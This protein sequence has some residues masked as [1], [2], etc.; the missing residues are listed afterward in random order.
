MHETEDDLAGLETL[1]DRSYAAAGAHLRSIHTRDRRM[2]ARQVADRLQG[3]CL[4]VVATVTADGRPLT[5]PVDGVF[6]RGSFHVGTDAGS[7]RWRHVQRNPAVSATH[8]PGEA[9]AVT[10]HGRAVPAD[11]SAADTSGL[12]SA[13]LEIYLPRY[14]P[15]WQDFLD[16]GPVYL[17]IEAER[18]FAVDVTAGSSTYSPA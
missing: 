13:L 9:W 15:G 2:T 3:M 16:S 4:L 6:H 12:R 8:L 5:G 18:L 17:R 14:G 1:L 10:V 7:V 11:T